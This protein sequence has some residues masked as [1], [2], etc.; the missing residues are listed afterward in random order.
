MFNKSFFENSVTNGIPVLE[1][2]D[3]LSPAK[4]AAPFVVPLKRSELRG[5]IIGPLAALR[6]TQY[7]GYSSEAC[8]KVLEALY[9]FPLPGDA[10]VSNVRV[11]F[12]DVEIV[13]ELKEREQAEAEYKEA[14]QQGK[15][16]TLATRESPDVFT[17]RVAGI[18][19]EQEIAVETSYVQL[20]KAEGA[21]FRVRIP[22]TTAPRFVRKDELNSRHAQG[23]PLAL[24][25]DPGH[26]FALDLTIHQVDEAYSPTHKLDL[27][28]NGN[29]LN[30]T[31]YD[32][33]VLPDRDCVLRWRAAQAEKRPTLHVMLH[34]DQKSEQL[35]FLALV[36]P[37]ATHDYGCGVPR[38]V[39]LLVDHSGSMNGA[40]WEAADW[41]VE[42]FLS[43]LSEQDAFALGLFH[44]RTQWWKRDMTH[45]RENAVDEAVDY[46]KR[47]RDSGGTN[48]GVALEQALNLRRVANMPARH[49]LMVTDAQVTDAGR[50]LRLADEEA[51][52]KDKRRISVICIDAAPNN[53]LAS[54]LA[55]RGGGVCRFLTSNPNQGDI[56]TALDE[57]LADW[58]EPVLAGLQLNINRSQVETF[59]CQV[60]NQAGSCHI[61]LGDLPAGRAIWVCG[62]VPRGEEALLFNL[63]AHNGQ[64]VATSALSTHTGG[65]HRALKALF[66]ARRIL[67]L[68][69]LI[70]SDYT[71]QQLHEQLH[72]LGY[73]AQKVMAASGS[74]S[75]YAENVRQDAQKALRGL[76]VREAL[77]YGLASAE[78]AFVAVRKE[79]GKPVEGTVAVAN[80]LPCG[81]SGDFL[82]AQAVVPMAYSMAMAGAAPKMRGIRSHQSH[83]A[84]M[85]PPSPQSDN[86]ERLSFLARPTKSAMPCAP[87]S[88]PEEKS[89]FKKMI[90]RVRDVFGDDSDDKSAAPPPPPVKNPS[91]VAASPSQ[92]AKTETLSSNTFVLFSGVP[93]QKAYSRPA[94]GQI[95]LFDSTQQPNNL[96]DNT[97]LRGLQITFPDGRPKA[98][99]LDRD[100]T[101]LLFV[102]DLSQPRAQVRL[103]DIVRMRGKRPLNLMKQAGDPL[104]LV[105]SDPN[106]AWKTGAPRMEITLQVSS[107]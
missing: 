97:Q 5:E 30:V 22:L 60:T 12:G 19:P 55:A 48:L 25:R 77:N 95:V 39:I 43:D 4:D 17:L 81:W 44:T 98:R 38:E 21:D 3:G 26:R 31:L 32:G 13:A 56:T 45:A 86:A 54:E 71:G 80:A 100:L 102:G 103:A 27:K 23:Q 53:F 9:R 59:D 105:L 92:V 33:E 61:D 47:N 66:G 67:G 10:A 70:N 74:S 46:L 69:F 20:A 107:L 18:Q 49:L 84:P 58:A 89:F 87:A 72:R 62:R 68:E 7:F 65:D 104:R 83:S 88:L 41:T 40:K 82:M 64:E 94:H 75:V 79:E 24:L 14:K 51:R 29:H 106:G 37:P 42:R 78:T 34:E 16:A 36:A 101:M 76:L 85:A 15:Q 91:P 73:D 50:V 57:V 35:Y 52:R 28:R 99:Q 96:P 90:D 63:T 2:V 93:Q 8:D 6:L 1:V 11:H